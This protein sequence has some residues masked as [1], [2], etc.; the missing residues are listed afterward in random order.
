MKKI[1]TLITVLLLSLF[2]SAGASQTNQPLARHG[3]Y[4]VAKATV[5]RAADVAIATIDAKAAYAKQLEEQ[6][7]QKQIIDQQ[8]S[9]N[10]EKLMTAILEFLA[11]GTFGFWLVLSL[12][13][14]LIIACI[15]HDKYW[16][17]SLVSI[18]VL[19]FYWKSVIA[20][21]SIQGIILVTLGY[22]IAGVI[23]S[24]FRW[25]RYTKTIANGYVAKYGTSLTDA[26]FSNLRCDIRVYSH[27]SQLCS[28]IAYWPWSVM[29]NIVGDFVNTLY[30]S[31]Q[32]VY[33]SIS[34]KHIDKFTLRR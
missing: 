5:A 15:E 11:F 9:E 30:D 33:S 22:A 18:G 17:P 21:G 12:V 10:F 13:S 1:K 26:Q 31:V 14:I 2:V 25:Y 29:W 20:L 34:Q 27:K 3:K 7:K 6:E 8:R 28:W 4:A 32:K 23:W 19:A 24:I 16:W